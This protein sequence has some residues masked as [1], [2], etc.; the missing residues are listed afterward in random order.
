MFR[1]AELVHPAL[2]LAIKH[3]HDTTTAAIAPLLT[4]ESRYSL[5]IV[6][7]T[8]VFLELAMFSMV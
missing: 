8:H 4:P 3:D 7:R 5:I 6:C 1:V 2:H